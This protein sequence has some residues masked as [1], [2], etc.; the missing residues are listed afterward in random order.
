MPDSSLQSI[1]SRI[2]ATYS[3]WSR[4]TS[5]GTMRD[6][7]EQ[8]YPT[9]PILARSEDLDVS[10]LSGRFLSAQI[11]DSSYVVLYIHGGG[12]R[13][14]SIDSHEKLM[15]DIACAGGCKV[16]GVD[17]QRMPEQT[18][19]TQLEDTE[20]AY[21]WLLE[22]GYPAN[23]I[24]VAG[25]SAGG[26]LAASLIQLIRQQSVSQQSVL[27][28]RELPM[29]GGCILLSPWLDMTLAGKSYETRAEQDPVH[30]TA[31]LK[32]LAEAYLGNAIPP[33]DPLASPLFGEL[34]DL[35][36]TLIQ[37]GDCE[38]GLDDS[39]NYYQKAK[40]L[41]SPVELSIWPDMIHVFQMFASELDAGKNAIEEIGAFIRALDC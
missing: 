36:P 9:G 32:A 13:M 2:N 17:Y 14:G 20:R 29:P 41:G 31:M 4:K 12:F 30:Q 28:Q 19:P 1:I 5:I 21:R 40:A 35:P 18:Y 16:L 37:V 38:I 33:A 15:S 6:E 7:W 34:S 26:N 25:D 22:N 10:G 3:A 11:L 27:Q 8:L 23:R 24:I 39:V